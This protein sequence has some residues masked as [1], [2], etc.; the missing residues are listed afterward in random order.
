[1]KV[2]DLLAQNGNKVIIKNILISFL[3]KLRID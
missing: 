2:Y 1:M 3:I